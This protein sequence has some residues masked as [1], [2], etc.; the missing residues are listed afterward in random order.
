MQEAVVLS[1]KRTTL[2]TLSVMEMFFVYFKVAIVTGFVLGSP[3]IIFQIWKF[4]AAGLYPHERKY[5]TGY[6]PLA[7]SL[8]LGGVAVCQFLIIPAALD[9][10]LSFNKWLGIE[11][12]LRMTDWLSFAI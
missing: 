8:F 10:L 3:W 11:P 4:I 2:S 6:L 5:F 12:E 9:A 1:S 7:I